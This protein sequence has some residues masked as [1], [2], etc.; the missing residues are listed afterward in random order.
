MVA[1]SRPGVSWPSAAVRAPT[2]CGRAGGPASA[3]AGVDAS[4]AAAPRRWSL[5]TAASQV[6]FAQEPAEPIPTRSSPRPSMPRRTAPPRG[7]PPWRRRASPSRAGRPRS[8]RDRR[9]ASSR[10]SSCRVRRSGRRRGSRRAH[11]RWSRDRRPRPTRRRSTATGASRR[12]IGEALMRFSESS[13]SAA[14]SPIR[15]ARV[16]SISTR[17]H[18][19]PPAPRRSRG[20]LRQPACRWPRGP[21][22]EPADRVRPRERRFTAR[23]VWPAAGA[24]RRSTARVRHPRLAQ[25]SRR[26]SFECRICQ[27]AVGDRLQAGRHL[28][29]DR[30]RDQ[31]ASG[32]IR[33]VRLAVLREALRTSADRRRLAVRQ[34]STPARPR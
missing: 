31:A 6:R 11:R 3:P 14:F 12:P 4:R 34:C 17:G 13:R 24:R 8:P 16:S 7:A 27:P 26:Q 23:L 32:H 5:A 2:A 18:P 21:P 9:A 25:Q 22:G 19:A 20:A 30:R 1:S 10:G 33:Q 28:R 29:L 15:C